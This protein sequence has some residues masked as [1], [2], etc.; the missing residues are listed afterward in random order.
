MSTASDGDMF[1][2]SFQR[3][4]LGPL[5]ET[6]VGGDWDF[7]ASPASRRVYARARICHLACDIGWRLKCG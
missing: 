1:A 3:L 7:S 2:Y 5:I 4:K 6:Y